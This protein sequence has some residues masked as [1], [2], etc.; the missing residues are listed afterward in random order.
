MTINFCSKLFTKKDCGH[1]PFLLL[2]G[3][4]LICHSNLNSIQ[5]H[6]KDEDIKHVV[7][8]MGALKSAQH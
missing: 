1:H 2:E 3:L 5:K 8:S 6:F 7:F 4:Y